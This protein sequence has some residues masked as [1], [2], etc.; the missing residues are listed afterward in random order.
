MRAVSTVLSA[1]LAGYWALAAGWYVAGAPVLGVIALALGALGGAFVM[2]TAVPRARVKR[3]A[4]VTLFLFAL[5]PVQG[6]WEMGPEH[7]FAVRLHPAAE[8]EQVQRVW[9]VA[10]QDDHFRSGGLTGRENGGGV[11]VFSLHPRTSASARAAFA[12]SLARLPGV[13]SVRVLPRDR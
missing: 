6:V 7:A 1:L 8:P 5:V 9:D 10:G 11:L 13:A 12:R 2:P 3:L 4:R